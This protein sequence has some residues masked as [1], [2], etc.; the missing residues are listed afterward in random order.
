MSSSTANFQYNAPTDFRIA[1]TT[2]DEVPPEYR[3]AFTQIYGAIQQIIFTLV[4][5][6]G[7][8][9]RN[10]GQWADLAGSAVTLLAGNLNRFYVQGAEAISYGA[11]VSF[12][13]VAGTLQAVLAVAT[14]S[15]KPALGFCTAPD[16]IGVGLFGEV[17]IA[18]GVV[19]IGGLTPGASYFLSDSP[20]LISS[21]PGTIS[22]YLGFAVTSTTLSFFLAPPGSL[23]ATPAGEV[24]ALA[25][26]NI[27]YGA[28][29]SFHDVAGV[30]NV[31][32]ANATNNTKPCQGFCS[33][34]LGLTTGNSGPSLTGVG[35]TPIGGL[36]IGDSYYLSTT[37]GL[38][39][40]T[41][42]VAVG[43]I[44]QFLGFA[45]STTSL[46]FNVSSWRQH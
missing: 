20:G 42:A 37:D 32:N 9:P 27:A 13:N 28:A 6:A 35:V 24:T 31:R 10:S 29:I 2:P 12:T 38:V 34:P 5:N 33:A 45:T 39:A 26:E 7:I 15:S 44:E 1:Q 23:P 18:A 11:A 14:D 16:G 25:S 4:N 36:T 30:L 3:A 19:S 43:N 40:P 41:P 46:R 17:V 21:T 22:Q 8:G